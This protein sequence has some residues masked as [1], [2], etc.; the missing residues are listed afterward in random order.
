MSDVAA[1][2]AN[3]F[4]GQDVGEVTVQEVHTPHCPEIHCCPLV[5]GIRN[6]R[7]MKHFSI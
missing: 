7:N 2:G 3:V 4:G 1:A 5:H 6:M